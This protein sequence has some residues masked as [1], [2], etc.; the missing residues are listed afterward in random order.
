MIKFIS[1][2][3]KVI[4]FLYLL[5]IPLKSDPLFEKG[6]NVFLNKGSCGSCHALSDAGAVG[7][8]GPNLD[9]L[10][11]ETA[12]IANAVSNGIGV[13]PAFEGMLSY[14]EIEAVSYYVFKSTNK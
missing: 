14:E 1:L 8:I 13:M 6:K 4:I 3:T 9:D 7:Q 12:R 2:F 11:P 10:K 5:T